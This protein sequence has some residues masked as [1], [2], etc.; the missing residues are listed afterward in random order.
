MPESSRKGRS[1]VGGHSEHVDIAITGQCIT[2]KLVA[3]NSLP[4]PLL[5]AASP[6]NKETA[7]CYTLDISGEMITGLLFLFPSYRWNSFIFAD[8][9]DTEI[10]HMALE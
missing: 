1:C 6:L 8:C 10:T 9:S 7:D 3:F 5:P 2:A 4:P